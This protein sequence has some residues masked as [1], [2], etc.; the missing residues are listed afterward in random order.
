ML[1]RT[2]RSKLLTPYPPKYQRKKG[3]GIPIVTTM[4]ALFPRRIEGSLSFPFCGDPVRKSCSQNA[5]QYAGIAP[6]HNGK[7]IA[8]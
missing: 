7:K 3:A 6:N 4:R 5:L 2:L 1:F 8:R